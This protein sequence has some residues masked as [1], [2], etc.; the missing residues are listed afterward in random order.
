MRSEDL[1]HIGLVVDDLEATT[2]R[3]TDT[4][5][6]RWTDI[7]ETEQLV[8]TPD[9]DITLPFR[10]TFSQ[11]TGGVRLE[12]IQSMPG[13]IWVPADSGLHHMG[14]WSDDVERDAAH[15]GRQGLLWEAKSSL[16]DGS[17]RLLWSY[18]KHPRGG[19]IELLN[20][21]TKPHLQR[22]WES[23]DPDSS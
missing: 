10:V 7:T 19:R 8:S 14:Y 1:F 12:L 23:V 2:R 21:S 3:M 13:T 22:S 20:R 11:A 17:Q 4:A 18:H 15:L 5:G 16:P 6:Y 9:G